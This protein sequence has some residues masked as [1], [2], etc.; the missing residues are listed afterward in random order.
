MRAEERQQSNVEKMRGVEP[1]SIKPVGSPHGG[2]LVHTIEEQE[3]GVAVQRDGRRWG[4]EEAEQ[5]NADTGHVAVVDLL[6]P[7]VMRYRQSLKGEGLVL[8][9][10]QVFYGKAIRQLHS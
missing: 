2:C 10:K 5:R 6:A 3:E 7:G 1:L 8:V 4:R 9:Y